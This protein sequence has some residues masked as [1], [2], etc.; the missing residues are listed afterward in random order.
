MEEKTIV[1]LSKHERPCRRPC[2]N[3]GVPGHLKYECNQQTQ[4]KTITVVNKNRK[5][6]EKI[7]Q[8]I[9]DNPHLLNIIVYPVP[10]TA[11]DLPDFG[12]KVMLHLNANIQPEQY[13]INRPWVEDPIRETQVKIRFLDVVTKNKFTKSLPK[14]NDLALSTSDNASPLTLV[15][16]NQLL[17]LKFRNDFNDEMNAMYRKA[18]QLTEVFSGVT[19]TSCGYK[20]PIAIQYKGF[21]F[22]C[23]TNE[24][25]NK[26]K[27]LL[28]DVEKKGEGIIPGVTSIQGMIHMHL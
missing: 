17:L 16:D 2:S 21:V 13:E 5:N 23:I 9:I 20:A 4:T 10:I 12:K 27:K 3:C 18:L 11:T 28:E 26:I 25:F 6:R 19:V 24:S 8:K 22:S 1:K 14:S 7:D 15:L